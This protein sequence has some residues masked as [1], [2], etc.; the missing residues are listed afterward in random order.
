MSFDSTIRSSV[1][2]SVF[3]ERPQKREEL[4]PFYRIQLQT[5][6]MPFDRVGFRSRG[7]PPFGHMGR[8]QSVRVEQLF[9]ACR[10]AIVQVVPTVPDTF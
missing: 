9:E 7:H 5:K 8:L 2:P 3:S 4:V 6:L 1:K 10:G